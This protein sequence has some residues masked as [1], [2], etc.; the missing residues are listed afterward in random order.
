[1]PYENYVLKAD[2]LEEAKDLFRTSAGATL[3]L[4]RP[5]EFD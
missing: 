3:I 5:L 2:Q 4:K 1:M